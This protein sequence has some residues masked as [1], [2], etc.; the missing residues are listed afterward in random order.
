MDPMGNL[1]KYPF[2]NFLASLASFSRGVFFRESELQCHVI[3]FNHK[4]ANKK[5]TSNGNTWNSKE[6]IFI[7][8]FSWMMNQI[9]T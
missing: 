2:Q 3:A 6:P 8:C 5:P 1:K 9:F 7:G 4:K